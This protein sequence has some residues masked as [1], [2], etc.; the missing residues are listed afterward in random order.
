MKK[1]TSK[2]L[3]LLL[4]TSMEANVLSHEGHNKLPGSIIAPHGGQIKGTDDLYIELIHNSDNVQ[5]YITDHDFK[6]ILLNDIKIE[7]L[8]KY[9]KQMKSE[10][11]N[12]TTNQAKY[13]DA[14]IN[15]KGSHR[16]TLE[17][18]T[19]YKNKTDTINYNLEPQD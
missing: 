3:V 14:K 8:I 17:I 15:S 6:P 18:K 4:I 16:Y 11:I 5:I 19:K 9:P 10:K 7:G 2:I 12:F 1:C 13:F